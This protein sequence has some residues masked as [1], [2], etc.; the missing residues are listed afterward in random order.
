MK[1]ENLSSQ[2]GKGPENEADDFK[3]NSAEKKLMDNSERLAKISEELQSN[4]GS[5][6]AAELRK[7]RTRLNQEQ[8]KFWKEETPQAIKP[9]NKEAVI[10][11]KED[12]VTKNSLINSLTTSIKK[13]FTKKEDNTAPVVV[14]DTAPVVV[15]DTAPV[16]VNDTA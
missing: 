5:K 1:Q 15:N 8:N 9:Q 14:N 12:P 11:K 2:I 13:S 16:V 10:V 3:F 7:L 6:R 4:P